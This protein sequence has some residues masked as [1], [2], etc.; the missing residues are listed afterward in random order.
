MPMAACDRCGEVK[1]VP[2]QRPVQ[3]GAIWQQCECGAPL[4]WTR[5]VTAL[6]MGN[7][8]KG[9]PPVLD[10]GE[11]FPVTMPQARLGRGRSGAPL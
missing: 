10:P 11:P 9:P 1:T 3:I 2:A 5:I 7:A 4:R 6:A 8:P